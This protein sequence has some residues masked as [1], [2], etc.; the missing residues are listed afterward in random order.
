M[1]KTSLSLALI[2][3]LALTAC[4]NSGGSSSQPPFDTLPENSTS[5][6]VYSDDYH[7]A[8]ICFGKGVWESADRLFTF[9]DDTSGNVIDKSTQTGVGFEYGPDSNGLVFHLGTDANNTYT[10]AEAVNEQMVLL[11]WEDGTSETLCYLTGRDFFGLRAGVWKSAENTYTFY[12]E[13][14]GNV[15]NNETETGLAFSFEPSENGLM[16][17]LGSAEDNSPAI[18]SI[19]D[20]NT[21][22]LT[23]PDGSYETLTYS[24]VTDFGGF[25]PGTW[26]S[27]SE[28]YVFGSDGTG[29]LCPNGSTET[30]EISYAVCDNLIIFDSAE[31]PAATTGALISADDNTVIIRFINNNVEILS[32]SGEE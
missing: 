4:S 12:N 20:E 8:S 6:P 1:K 18:V 25:K 10:T 2:A 28:T 31:L 3:A 29:T 24:P 9:Y 23:W 15:I 14:S 16:F 11:T 22:E 32:Y 17:H 30:I 27:D 19:I 26:S 7:E 21:V 5:M 13:I